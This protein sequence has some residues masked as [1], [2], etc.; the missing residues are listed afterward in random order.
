MKVNNIY[1]SERLKKEER[2]KEEIKILKR[3]NNK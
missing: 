1:Y 3:K 2:K